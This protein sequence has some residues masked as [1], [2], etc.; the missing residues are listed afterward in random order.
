MD[1]P[2][3][4]PKMTMFEDY[5]ECNGRNIYDVDWDESTTEGNESKSYGPPA[6]PKV[7]CM[8]CGKEG[9]IWKRFDQGWRL[10][11]CTLSGPHICKKP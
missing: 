5:G 2:N 10:V 3:F 8:Y 4:Q 1:R 6:K 7:T 9:L 11:E